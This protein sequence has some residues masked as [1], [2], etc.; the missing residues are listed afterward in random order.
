MSSDPV[1]P[2]DSD[3]TPVPPAS[4]PVSPLTTDLAQTTSTGL[5]PNVAAG[6]CAVLTIIG[7]VIFIILEKKN[8]FVRFW[9]MQSIF[10][11]GA[12][13]VLSIVFSIVGFVLFR[14]P[15]IG[16][17]WWLVTIVIDLAMLAVWLVSVVKAFSGQTWEIPIIG[18]MARDQLTKTPML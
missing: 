7:G 2:P 9:A 4:G 6:L 8:Q 1:L 13:I 18:K 11:G 5:A 15:L 14:I 16:W 17:L 10:F 3:P 12:M